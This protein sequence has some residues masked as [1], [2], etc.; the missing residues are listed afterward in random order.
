MQAFRDFS[1]ATGLRASP[2]KCKLYFGGVDTKT[3]DMIVSKTGFG[4][5]TIPFRYL[6]FL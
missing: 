4:R 5:G 1:D 2:T 6:G 3:Q